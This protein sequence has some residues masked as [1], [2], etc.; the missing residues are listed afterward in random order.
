VIQWRESGGD[1]LSALTAF[2]NMVL[3]ECCP[4]EAGRFIFG[5]RLL[6]S[7]HLRKKQAASDGPTH[8]H[9]FHPYSVMDLG[10]N[11]TLKRIISKVDYTSKKIFAVL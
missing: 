10:Y 1:F 7:W 9:W 8:R 4:P 3:A 6:A 5:D 11:K 2:V